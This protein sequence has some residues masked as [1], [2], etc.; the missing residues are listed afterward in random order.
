MSC[1][2]NLSVGVSVHQFGHFFKVVVL[3]VPVGELKTGVYFATVAVGVVRFRGP[4]VYE[5]VFNCLGS[6]ES[7]HDSVVVRVVGGVGLGVGPMAGKCGNF[8]HSWEPGAIL[9]TP[10]GSDLAGFA[11][12]YLLVCKRSTSFCFTVMSCGVWYGFLTSENFLNLLLE[13]IPFS[14]HPTCV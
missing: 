10:P 11:V 7:G 12:G 14:G 9:A 5:H 8:G 6:S 13:R 3:D 1:Y 4:D 2:P